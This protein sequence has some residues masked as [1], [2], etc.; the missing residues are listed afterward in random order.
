M[1]IFF[2]G[3]TCGENII[4]GCVINFLRPIRALCQIFRVMANM[5]SR[6]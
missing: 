3:V 5:V 2:S 1:V 4:H 6:P